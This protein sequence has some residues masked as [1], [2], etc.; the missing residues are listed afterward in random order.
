M[1]VREYMNKEPLQV[2]LDTP[3]IQATLLIAR[4]EAGDVCV[5]DE[6]NQLCG[7][8]SVEN[9]INKVLRG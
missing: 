5:V 2:K 6:E 7:V 9:I 1:P 3:L 8:F 4:Q